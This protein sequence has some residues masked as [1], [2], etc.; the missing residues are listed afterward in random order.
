MEVDKSCPHYGSG[1]MELVEHKFFNCPLS[2]QVCRML[3][4][5]SLRKE[6][7][8]AIGVFLNDAMHL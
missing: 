7:T 2:Q 8:L 5:N 4:S 3:S 1:A 6:V